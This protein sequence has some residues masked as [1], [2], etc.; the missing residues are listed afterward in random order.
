VH[1]DDEVGAALGSIGGRRVRGMTIAVQRKVP[2]AKLSACHL[3]FLPMKASS[4]LPRVLEAV[5]GTP[6]MVV[7]DAEAGAQLGAAISLVEK[8]GGRLG[9]EL[10]MNA[11]RAAG[12]KVSLRM[13]ELAHKVY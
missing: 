13:I 1:D 10:N 12:L 6:V 7:V 5:A 8:S 4:E 9:F 3:A 11:M 2:L